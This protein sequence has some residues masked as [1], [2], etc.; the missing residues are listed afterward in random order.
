MDGTESAATQDMWSARACLDKALIYRRQPEG[1]IIG[2]RDFE[3]FSSFEK[4]FVVP[5]NSIKKIAGSDFS[6]AL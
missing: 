3:Y 4:H 6:Q 2:E 5:W 1:Q